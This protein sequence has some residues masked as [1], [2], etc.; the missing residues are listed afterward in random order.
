MYSL[1]CIRRRIDSLRRKYSLELGVAE[2]HTIS[3]EFCGQWAR[4]VGDN[5]P[6]PDYHMYPSRIGQHGFRFQTFG[7]LVK[8]LKRCHEDNE[9]PDS[10][11]IISSLLPQFDYRCLAEFLND[12]CCCPD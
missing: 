4:A 9:L 7:V 5:K 12:S 2:L 11:G 6:V 1:S 10:L 8:Y 3:E